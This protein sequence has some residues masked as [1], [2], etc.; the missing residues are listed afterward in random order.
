MQ[1]RDARPSPPHTVTIPATS[2]A[3]A[4]ALMALWMAFA[5]G[6]TVAALRRS[7]QA[8]AALARLATL[9]AL[10]GTGPALPMLIE[11]GGAIDGPQRLAD[12]LA[13]DRLPDLFSSLDGIR[14]EDFAELGQAVATASRGGRAFEM[15][16]RLA[17]GARALV[18]HGGPAPGPMAVSSVLLWFVDATRP[19]GEKAALSAERQDVA[20]ALSA[21]ARLIEAAPFPMWHRG[22]D[23][24]LALVN[25]AYVKAVEAADAATVIARGIELLEPG[26]NLDPRAAA[27]EAR[28]AGRA[29]TRTL[30]ATVAGERRILRIMDVP[31]GDGGGVA[32]FAFD[33][34]ELEQAKADLARFARAQRDMLDRLSSGV[35]QFGS[36]RA[37]IFSNQPFARMFGMPADWLAERPEFDRVLERM[38]DNHQLPEV[39]DF[40][41]W[42][43]ER[44][45]WFLGLPEAIE[46]AWLLPG[47]AHL[48][49]VAQPLPDGGLLLIFEDRTEQ[50]QLASAR[51]TL[52]RVR[53]A[54]FENLFEAIGVFAGDGR[55]YLWNNRFREVWGLEEEQLASHPRV[56]ELVP[57]LARSLSNP[58][59]AGLVRELVRS[60]TID[61]Q[62]RAGRVRLGDGRHFEFAAVPLPDGNALFTMLDVTDSRRIETA[63]RERTDAL[64]EADRVKTA[65]VAGMSYELRT[66]L[67]SIAG[68]AEMLAGGYGGAL[69][70]SA[71]DYVGAILEATDR[72]GKLIDDVLDL[73]QSE[74]GGLLRAVPVDL[75]AV[76]REAADAFATA[77]ATAEI[78]LALQVG[79]G[80]GSVQGDPRR[81][82]EALHHLLRNAIGH[83]ASGGRI[84]LHADGDRSGAVITVS[85]NGSGIAPADLTRVFD[86]FHGLAEGSAGA[87]SIGLGLP[88]ARQFVEAHGGTVE[89]V[90]EPG[91]GTSVTIRLPR[92]ARQA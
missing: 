82:R 7:R 67:T 88:L 55:L 49:V 37:L 39:R 47:G 33:V 68:F 58:D 48:R 85:D 65:F 63:L 19:E 26:S 80:V 50:V 32:G 92:A 6:A 56:D 16:V 28:T 27:G 29:M 91:L 44:R 34:Q 66:P 87:V 11:P 4:A 41:E 36:D 15:V 74:A 20:A 35:A 52:L 73:T 75:S 22:P 12:A 77:A 14:A 23:L 10:L 46:E 84:L 76:A 3:V 57:L 62:Q 18:V 59:H 40:P 8:S 72:L 21:L 24:S 45:E 60:A 86:R 30:P 53:T 83:T 90:S 61:R 54:T 51:D 42:K 89:L 13:L 69:D 31:L 5:I 1:A 79:D 25:R 43:A 64:E 81:L 9:E 71:R 2:I 70:E 17:A 78:E 38:R